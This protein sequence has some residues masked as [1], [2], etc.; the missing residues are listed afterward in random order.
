VFPVVEGTALPDV[1]TEFATV[2]EEPLTLPIEVI[3]EHRDRWIG[4]WTAT[5]LR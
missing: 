4:A 3:G 5:V 1:F 2:P